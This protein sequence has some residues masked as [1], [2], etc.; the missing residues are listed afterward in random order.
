MIGAM[1][2][3]KFAV[4]HP[5]ANYWIRAILVGV[6][7]LAVIHFLGIYDFLSEKVMSII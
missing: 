2:A 5:K 4:G 7:I 6:I 1:W 3:A